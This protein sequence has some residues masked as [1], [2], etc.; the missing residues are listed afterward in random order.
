MTKVVATKIGPEGIAFVGQFQNTVTIFT[1][2]S[3]GLISAG[4]VK[5]LAEHYEDPD[6]QLKVI[7]TGY[8]IVLISAFIV[9]I[10]ILGMSSY[11]SNA[12]FHSSSFQSVY[13]FYGGFIILMALNTFFSSVLNGF[14]LILKLTLINIVGS[15]AGV[16]FT[17][18]FAYVW[19]VKGVLIAGNFTALIIFIINAF[20]MS[21]VDGFSWRPSFSSWDKPILK[22][23]SR[24]ILMSLM[25]F[26]MPLTQLVI[27]NEILSKYSIREAG[28]WQAVTRIS[29]YYLTFITT[30]LSVYYVPR[31]SE[32]KEKHELRKE[33]ISGY[34]IILPVVSLLA[35]G[36]WVFRTLIVHLLF[37]KEFLPMIP[38]FTFQLAGDVIKIAS[39][40][41]ACVMMARAMT[42]LFVITEILFSICFT[43]LSILF[44]EKFGLI[45]AT[46]A[47][48]LNYFLYF[49]A[50][51]LLLRKKVF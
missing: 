5:Y 6:K 44:I 2:A 11:L 30:V 29:D 39:W 37:S 15:L 26:L 46:Y 18:L 32:I 13:L 10:L 31:L 1:L 25:S 40:I 48:C 8:K 21:K 41:I 34:K 9:A 38:L 17:V 16:F 28:Y 7:Q 12:V 19:G 36:I 4:V 22:S 3:T 42:R 23:F 20:Y 14:K 49:I 45:G 47:F 51:F 50:T 43:V 27:R 24:Y 35:L 33:I